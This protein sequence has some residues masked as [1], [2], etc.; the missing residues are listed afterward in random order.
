MSAWPASWHT[1]TASRHVEGGGPGI[2]TRPNHQAHRQV[3]ESSVCTSRNGVQG[4]STQ[5]GC[6]GFMA[7]NR[8]ARA[9]ALVLCSAVQSPHPAVPPGRP[10]RRQPS[11]IVASPSRASNISACP[12]SGWG[13]NQERERERT[14]DTLPLLNK[15][16]AGTQLLVRDIHEFPQHSR[17]PSAAS[18]PARWSAQAEALTVPACGFGGQSASRSLSNQ[19]TALLLPLSGTFLT[20]RLLDR[21]WAA[22]V[23]LLFLT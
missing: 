2:S 7:R 1:G 15:V 9:R 18:E 5:P 22:F 11:P 6:D 16:L 14:H 17:W 12:E 23:G 4:A 20:R 8:T 10:R 21:P 13:L 3:G 19:P